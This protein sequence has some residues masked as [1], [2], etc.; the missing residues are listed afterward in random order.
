MMLFVCFVVSCL[1]I[2]V[3][4]LL[5]GVA[6]CM[7]CVVVALLVFVVNGFV[8]VCCSLSNSRCVMYVGLCRF[9]CWIL[10]FVVCCGCLLFVYVRGCA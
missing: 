3:V 7:W 1:L 10:E 9:F 6:R 8:G 5:C 4:S 2:D